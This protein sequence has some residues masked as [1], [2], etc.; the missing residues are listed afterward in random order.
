VPG[1]ARRGSLAPN[2]IGDASPDRRMLDKVRALLAKAESIEY[3]EEAESLSAKAEE[4]MARHRI[5][6][7]LLAADA[8]T[9]DA[10]VGVRVTIDNP[11]EDPKATLLERVAEANGCRAAFS[12]HARDVGRFK[13]DVRSP[14]RGRP[15]RRGQPA[16]PRP[17]H[18]TR[19]EC[20]LRVPR[21]RQGWSGA[22]SKGS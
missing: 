1:T 11:Y 2:Q 5:D 12:N 16:P 6:Y 17:E 3:A 15:S 7:A 21:A 20:G 8:G 22:T 4:L 19:R 10:P 9:R 14:R 18:G 13:T